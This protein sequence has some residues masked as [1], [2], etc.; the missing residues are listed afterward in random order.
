MNCQALDVNGHQCRNT[1]PFCSYHVYM[2]EYTQEMIQQSTLCSGCRKM[3]FKQSKICDEC[4]NRVKP[5]KLI[6]KCAKDGCTFK[7]SK[8][9]KYCGKHQMFIFVDE[10]TL[11]G[12][13]CCKQVVRG[14]RNQLPLDGYN[15][16][17]NCLQIERDKDHKRRSELVK[18]E[19]EK[20]CSVCCKL[21]PMNAFNGKLGETKTCMSCREANKRADEKRDMQHVRALANQNALKP[22]RKAVKNIWKEANY[23]KV[24]GYW[25]EA[26]ARLIESNLEGFLKR[27]AEQAKHWRDANPEKVKLIN[28]QKNDNIDYHFVNYNRSAETK[29]L[30]FTITKGDFMDM[31]V[32]PCYYCGIIQSKGFNGIDRVNSTQGYKLDNVVSCCEMCNMMKGCLGPTIFI[33]RAEHIVTHLKMVNGTLY[34]DDFKDIITVNYKKYK[35]RASERSIDFMISKEF[36]EEKTKESCYLCGKMPSQTH[37]NGLDR[38]DNTVGYIEDNC[39]S[40]CGNCNYIK[41]DN[42]YDAFMNKCMLIYYKHKKETKNDINGIEET[43]QI[44]KG[45]K[46]TDEQKREKERIRKQ[47]Q[48]DALRKKYGDE[49][50]KKLHAKQIAEQRKKNKEDV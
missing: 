34:P 21:Q 2:N 31:V 16:C 47:A 27:S 39:K 36:L 17:D 15:Q 22:E 50:Y 8:E 30:E 19:T 13:K 32:L 43:R 33:H 48:R 46:L 45:N 6:I 24:A 38:M 26:R 28:Q 49:E 20:Q 7:K 35:M 4:K 23:E 1:G 42:T 18:N 44:V 40:C 5:S 37:K 12:L 25:L 41:R 29:Q 10:T 11:L 14:C 9:N 3:K